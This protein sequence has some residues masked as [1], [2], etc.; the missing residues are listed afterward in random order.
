[1][2]GTALAASSRSTVMRTISEPARAS[3]AHWRAVPATS[4]VS[5]LVIDCTTIGASP[6]TIT[7]P[8]STGMV[9][10]RGA[11]A[12]GHRS[13][14]IRWLSRL[15]RRMRT[16]AGAGL[17]KVRC[18][19]ARRADPV[20][21]AHRATRRTT[22]GKI[23][24]TKNS[25]STSTIEGPPGV[26]NEIDMNRPSGHR[27][28]AEDGGEQRHLLRRLGQGRAAAAGMIRKA[29]VRSTP[30]IL[31]AIATTSAS[32]HEDQLGALGSGALGGGQILVHGE[33]QQRPPD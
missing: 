23:A 25:A 32:R 20:R 2:C 6:P 27:Q 31:M 19:V 8:T 30:T 26:S 21:S 10:L 24:A 17:G 15:A 3:A 13:L 4:A 5:V 28:H 12:A 11:G 29:M 14:A 9:D 22:T 16:S 18:I 33:R 7:P 1:M